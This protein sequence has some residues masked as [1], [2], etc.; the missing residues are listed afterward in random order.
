[1]PVHVVQVGLGDRATAQIKRSGTPIVVC[2]LDIVIRVRPVHQLSRDGI[3]A[4]WHWYPPHTAGLAA[5]PRPWNPASRVRLCVCRSCCRGHIGHRE[6]TYL[7]ICEHNQA[8]QIQARS[9]T[10][11]KKQ[12]GRA[13]RSKL[14]SVPL[15]FA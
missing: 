11:Y 4:R 7:V 15:L 8:S 2:Q 9:T 6:R 12:K 13:R 1:M 10:G 5:S 14:R 3:V